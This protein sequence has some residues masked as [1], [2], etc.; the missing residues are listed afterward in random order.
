MAVIVMADVHG[1]TEAGYDGMLK[2]LADP[3]RQAE[4]FVLHSA[5]CVDGRWHVFEVW[6]SK[7]DADRFFARHVAPHLPPGVRPKRTVVEA[8]SLV[9]P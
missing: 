6:R 8:H 2:V 1:Q 3:I 5:Y 7:A 9:T 4:G